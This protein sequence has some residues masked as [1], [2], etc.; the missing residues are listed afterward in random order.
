MIRVRPVVLV[1]GIAGVVGECVITRSDSHGVNTVYNV[2]DQEHKENECGDNS[3]NFTDQY[4][5]IKYEYHCLDRATYQIFQ[6]LLQRCRWVLIN[7]HSQSSSPF[8]IDTYGNDQHV[9]RSLSDEAAREE[10]RM[11]SVLQLWVGFTSQH[12]LIYHQL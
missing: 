11:V 4:Y 2:V 7:N 10:E 5:L 12:R 8:G 1:I 3:T 9:R 6:L